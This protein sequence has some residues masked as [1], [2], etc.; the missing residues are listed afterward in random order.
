MSGTALAAG[1]FASRFG[2][3]VLIVDASAL[4]PKPLTKSKVLA[5]VGFAERVCCWLATRLAESWLESRLG[6]AE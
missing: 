5:V 2:G 1:L 4:A 6:I 3:V